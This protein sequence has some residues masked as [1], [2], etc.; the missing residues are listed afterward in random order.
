MDLRTVETVVR[1]LFT[2][3]EFRARAIEDSA[4]ALSEYRLGAAEHAALSKLCLQLASGPK[5]NAAP[6]GTLGWW[7]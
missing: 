1:R 6:I 7:T 2:D 3:A 5:F 4:A